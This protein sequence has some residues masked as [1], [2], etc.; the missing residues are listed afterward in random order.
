MPIWYALRVISDWPKCWV[1]RAA[2]TFLDECSADAT[3]IG[4]E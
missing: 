1:M 4:P 2:T 3:E